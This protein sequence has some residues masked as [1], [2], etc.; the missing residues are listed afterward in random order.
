MTHNEKLELL[1]QWEWKTS[2]YSM[3]LAVLSY[4][5]MTVAPAAG[6]EFRDERAA[7]LS[8]E[9]FDL[10]V[11]PKIIALLKDLLEDPETDAETKRKCE[12]YY[13][14]AMK[15]VSVPKEEYVAYSNLNNASYNAWYKARM[16]NDYAPFEPYLK[17]MIESARKLV[18]Y[19]HSE[20]TTYDELLN[21]YQP[22][23]DIEK[24][25]KFFDDVEKRLVPLI[26]KVVA[27]KPVD[28]SFLTQ[29]YDVDKQR[30]FMKRLVKYLHYDEDWCYLGE[31]EHPF[32]VTICANDSRTTTRYIPDNV[33]SA[34]LS[35]IHEVGHAYYGH[36]VD[37]KYDGNILGAGMSSGIHESQ[38]RLLEN[39]LGRSLPFWKPIYPVLQELFPEQL[40]KVT[41]EQFVDAINASSPSLIRTEADELTY[42]IHVM[43]RYK[44]EK[45]LFNGTI[46]TEGLDKTW[47]EMY[48][49][50]LGVS[51]KTANEGILQDVHWADG[52]FGY[53]PTYALGSAFSAQFYAK[54]REQI[55]VDRL[56]EEDRFNEITDWLK[57][58][59]HR[60]GNRYDAE[61]VLELATGERFNS[62][63]YFRYLEDKYTKLYHLK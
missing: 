15:I 47:N 28:T 4:D 16:E 27:A 56:M 45:G 37:P 40:G 26:K 6:A 5:K 43:I 11:D 39:Y 24:F 21:D 10:S 53:F 52:L 25:D 35:T 34:P 20:K 1:K 50:Y 59:V 14:D 51:A 18:S 23:M 32:T 3:V 19:R 42:P 58:N 46:S 48:E 2:A 38:S 49:K 41:A 8:G 33:S 13:H 7:Y 55:D 54:M 61:D 9:V 57:E 29:N 60:Y 31:T 63:Y 22:G 12:C 62:E 44:L 17:Q 30:T 36:Q